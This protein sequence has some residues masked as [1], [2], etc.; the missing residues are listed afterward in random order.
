MTPLKPSTQYIPRREIREWTDFDRLLLQP[1]DGSKTATL[2]AILLTLLFH[3][4]LVMSIPWGAGEAP[5]KAPPPLEPMQVEYA[6]QP[7]PPPEMKIVEANPDAP[8]E[9]PEPTPNTSDRDQRAA[10]EKPS[11]TSNTDAPQ[12]KGEQTE[13][14]KI[15]TGDMRT[16]QPASPPP[17]PAKQATPARQPAQPTPPPTPPTPK[18]ETK[19]QPPAPKAETKP[20]TPSPS[21]A[22]VQ[23]TTPPT[24]KAE[25][26]PAAPEVPKAVVAPQPEI[27][28]QPAEKTYVGKPNETGGEGVKLVEKPVDSQALKPSDS[29]TTE[30]APP[31]EK[32]ADKLAAPA[33][34]LATVQATQ[35]PQQPPPQPTPEPPPTPPSVQATESDTTPMPRR[36]VKTRVPAGPL[37]T[38]PNGTRNAGETAISSNFSQFGNYEQRMLEAV[39]TQWNQLCDGFSFTAQDFGTRVVVVFTL[40]PQGEVIACQIV[41]STASRAATLLCSQAIQSR[42]PFGPWT[43]EMVGLLGQQQDVRI[44]FW[45]R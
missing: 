45:Y 26:K 41:N 39:S 44:T 36:Q 13:S 7:P 21:K 34:A 11:T 17:S 18:A 5:V 40:N 2:S 20:V 8:K 6:L 38:N 25:D 27:P 19:P 3:G 42:S 12:I 22:E 29:K 9:K 33:P 37:M 4:A 15:V 1:S 10:Q 30:E 35:P 24:P 32:P 16:P 28:A 14:T 31:T 43:K 23:P